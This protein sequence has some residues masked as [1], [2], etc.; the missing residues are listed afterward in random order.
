MKSNAERAIEWKNKKKKE[1]WK[2]MYVFAP[3]NLVF[4]VKHFVRQWKFNNPTIYPRN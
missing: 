1:G 3:S 2:A 4:D